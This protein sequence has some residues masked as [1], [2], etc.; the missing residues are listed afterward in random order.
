MEAKV[1]R[2]RTAQQCYEYLKEHKT[3]VP[4]G[5]HKIRQIAKSGDVPVYRCGESKE[6]LLINL[7]RLVEYL[8]DEL[9][10]QNIDN[11]YA[12]IKEQDPDTAIKKSRIRRLAESGKVRTKMVGNKLLVDREDLLKHLSGDYEDAREPEKPAGYGT[13]RRII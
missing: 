2:M 11:C 3:G 13:I 12:Y 8:D 7:D 10:M 4:I 1:P 9:R 5:I 6:K